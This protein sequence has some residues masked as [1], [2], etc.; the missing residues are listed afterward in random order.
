MLQNQGEQGESPWRGWDALNEDS[1]T[2]FG[3]P[4]AMVLYVV[5][6]YVESH[7]TVRISGPPS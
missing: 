1:A 5:F 3:M 2:L 6:G 7:S 4:M